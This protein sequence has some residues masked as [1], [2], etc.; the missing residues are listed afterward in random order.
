MPDALI[1]YTGFV[2]GNLLRQRTF[3]DQY[4][5]RNIDSI[6]GRGYEL[7]VCS[8]APAEKWKANA[9]P[10]RDRQVLGGLMEHLSQVSAARVVL[11][12]TVDVYPEPVAVDEV[13]PI[14]PERANAYG[15]HRYELERFLCERFDTLVVRLPGL[16]GQGLKKNVI[17]DFLHGN[18][19]E[20]I[21]SAGVFQFYDLTWLWKDIQVAQEQG[22]RVV[23]FATEPVSVEEVARGAFGREF[24]QRAPKPARYDI[25]SRHAALFGGRGGYL[26]DKAQVL[27][28]MKAFVSAQ[29]EGRQ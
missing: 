27:T 12:S 22:L 8:G 26:Y 14:D 2:G 18:R 16:F 21:N 6:R 24:I 1:G 19:L 29:R 13:S 23:N 17:Y 5:S 9:E 4:N 11:I 10:E 15:R 20:A 25:R 28:A 3:E 7:L